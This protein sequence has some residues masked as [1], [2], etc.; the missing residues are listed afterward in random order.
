MHQARSLHRHSLT[1]LALLGPRRKLESFFRPRAFIIPASSLPLQSDVR[2]PGLETAS[3]AQLRGATLGAHFLNNTRMSGC[4]KITK[5]QLIPPVHLSLYIET[6]SML[7]H[8]AAF[9]SAF[10]RFSRSLVTKVNVWHSVLHPSRETM[11]TFWASFEI[12]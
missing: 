9:L 4:L 12:R 5:P 3:L 6:Q 7:T 8:A 10:R 2:I 1:R 11:P